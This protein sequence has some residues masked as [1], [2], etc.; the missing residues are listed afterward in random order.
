M[1]MHN[2]CHSSVHHP[3][4]HLEFNMSP[5]YQQHRKPKW[6]GTFPVLSLVIVDGYLL[7]AACCTPVCGSSPSKLLVY[8]EG[9]V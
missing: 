5:Y 3:G 9:L 6:R 8:A 2:T 4:C 1:P 7:P